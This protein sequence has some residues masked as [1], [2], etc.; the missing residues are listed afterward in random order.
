MK[1]PILHFTGWYDLFNRNSLDAFVGI[2]RE[3]GTEA[4]RQGQ[5]L[6]VG[7]WGHVADK[8]LCHFPGTLVDD[9]AMMGEWMDRHLL[10]VAGE[11]DDHRVVL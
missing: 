5:R 10:G 7:P 6:I 4:A 1:A 9:V 11:G 3:G 2:S 8:M